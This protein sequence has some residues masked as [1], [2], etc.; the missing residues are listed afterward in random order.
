[1]M[2]LGKC[3]LEA[4]CQFHTVGY[5]KCLK[6]TVACLSRTIQHNNLQIMMLRLH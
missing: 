6:L 2:L 3:R 5:V 4:Y 1:M